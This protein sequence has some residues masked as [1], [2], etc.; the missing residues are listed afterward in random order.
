MYV[1]R[2]WNQP[3]AKSQFWSDLRIGPM[4]CRLKLL[5][6]QENGFRHDL[7]RAL[8]HARFNLAASYQG[9]W[10]LLGTCYFF[11]FGNSGN[12]N[13]CSGWDARGGHANSAQ[14]LCHFWEAISSWWTRLPM[15]CKSSIRMTMAGTRS[16]CCCPV[17][18]DSNAPT[19]RKFGKAF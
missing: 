4:S 8:N 12:F 18:P 5:M 1:L 11:S 14:I 10:K 6:C 19:S 13:G 17:W 9:N 15:A 3:S 7:L 16:C 2:S